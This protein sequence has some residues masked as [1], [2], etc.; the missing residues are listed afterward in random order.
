MGSYEEAE[1]QL[2]E[3]IRQQPGM[4]TAHVNLGIMLEQTGAKQAAAEAF[5]HAL[6]L[7][8]NRRDAASGLARIVGSRS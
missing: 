6:T 1:A 7:D 4:V 8:P 3:S 2:R 5:K